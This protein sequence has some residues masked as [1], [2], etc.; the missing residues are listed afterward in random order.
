MNDR[1][2]ALIMTTVHKAIDTVMAHLIQIQKNQVETEE[3]LK[4]IR[5]LCKNK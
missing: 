2:K 3:Y 1:E 4:E 5:E